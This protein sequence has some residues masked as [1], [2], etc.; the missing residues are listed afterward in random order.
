MDKEFSCHIGGIA[1]GNRLPLSVGVRSFVGDEIRNTAYR[2]NRHVIC[3]SGLV[4]PEGLHVDSDA[5][6]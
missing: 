6:V 4:S 1:G 3:V 5:V 2:D